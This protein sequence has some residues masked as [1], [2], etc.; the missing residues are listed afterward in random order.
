MLGNENENYQ[1]NYTYKFIWNKT[2]HS[3]NKNILFV[4]F[5]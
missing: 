5:V 4:H 2:I 1:Q 3:R